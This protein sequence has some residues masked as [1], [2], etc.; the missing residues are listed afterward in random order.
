MTELALKNRER[1]F[2]IKITVDYLRKH[3]DNALI[4]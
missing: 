3:A 2:R 4:A 1:Q